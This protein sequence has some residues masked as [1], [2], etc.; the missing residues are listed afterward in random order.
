MARSPHHNTT[1]AALLPL[2][3]A[4]LIVTSLLPARFSTPWVKPLGAQSTVVFAPVARTF[5]LVGQ[6]FTRPALEADAID[7]GTA[8][9][10][11][12]DLQ[13][14][15]RRLQSENDELRQRNAELTNRGS[16]RPQTPVRLML[17]PVT[18]PG[19]R[20]MRVR[21][22]EGDGVT[23]NTFATSGLTQLVGRVV[24]IE[25]R[26]SIIQPITASDA[27]KVNAR[28]LFDPGNAAGLA[29]VLESMGDGTLTGP[30]TV[31]GRGSGLSGAPTITAGQT[32]VLNDDRWPAHAQFFVL[33]LVESVVDHPVTSTRKII[34]V[35]P[36]VDVRRVSEVYLQIPLDA[37][38][39]RGTTGGSP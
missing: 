39:P 37:E 26:T 21:G 35:I 20:L 11:I 22:G 17:R 32:V 2:A 7:P 24:G 3:V 12:D 8:K 10:A 30:V 36:T 5:N 34:T 27:P 38:T 31:E 9:A 33:G 25:N 6:L 28:V 15:N 13:A 4:L 14:R 19:G 23:L 1:A 29:C 16:I 18:E